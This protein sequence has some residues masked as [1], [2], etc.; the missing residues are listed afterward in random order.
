M[1]YVLVH[2]IRGEAV[3]YEAYVAGIDPETLEELRNYP[4]K[5]ANWLTKFFSS[6]VLYSVRL[7]YEDK[8][9]NSSDK[10]V[11]EWEDQNYTPVS[12]DGDSP[13]RT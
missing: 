2:L 12:A 7:W 3:E 10:I 11:P 1:K 5:L 8:N 13:E 4:E 6:P 9:A